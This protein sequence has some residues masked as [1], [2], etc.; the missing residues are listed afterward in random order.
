MD[1]QSSLEVV[2]K[3]LEIVSKTDVRVVV[4]IIS[5]SGVILTA[6][7]TVW[8]VN[9]TNKIAKDLGEK[10]LNALE[11]RRYIDAERVKWINEFR[12]KSSEFLKVANLQATDLL[13]FKDAIENKVDISGINQDAQIERSSE[14]DGVCN[15]INLLLNP[16]DIFS[17]YLVVL[18]N[19]VAD[20]LRNN[21]ILK[22]NFEQVKVKV[23]DIGYLYHVIIRSEWKRI[24]EENKNGA[25][26]SEEKMHE[27]YNEI[28]KKL[29][30]KAYRKF[31]KE[32]KVEAPN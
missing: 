14:I 16:N 19:E 27:I 7:I 24:K 17:Y 21:N 22:F 5:F 25:E 32:D 18:Q 3:S 31:I 30:E 13:K 1:L 11:Q 9:K 26:L 4:G 20:D 12:E 28:A 6:F 15:Q 23:E 2:S 29:D 8:N 10:N